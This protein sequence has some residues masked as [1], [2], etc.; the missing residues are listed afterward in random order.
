[1]DRE[2]L[3][4]LRI[5]DGRKIVSQ[6][7]SDGFDVAVAFWVKTPEGHWHLYVAS[8]QVTPET[9]GDCSKKLHAA[10]IKL[11]G[12]ELFLYT[13]RLVAADSPAAKAAAE[14]RRRH[15]GREMLSTQRF[16][17]GNADCEEVHIYPTYR[18][19][20]VIAK[21]KEEVLRQLEAETLKRAGQHGEWMLA[22]DETGSLIAFIEGHSFVGSGAV[23]LGDKTLTI[24]DGLVVSTTG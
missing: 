9:F 13:L 10:L 15:P 7:V 19:M 11:G 1:M 6:L 8:P 23:R 12:G 4:D 16:R 5:E 18:P 14:I 3:V 22:R 17:I 20:Q 21:G 24:Q 2:L